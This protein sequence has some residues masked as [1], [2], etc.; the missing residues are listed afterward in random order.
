M[1]INTAFFPALMWNS[2]FS[3]LSGDPF[4]NSAGFVFPAPEGSSLSSEPHLLTAQAF[5]PPTERTE[6]A[7]F[8]FHG[9]N[10]AI[11]AEVA[12][13]ID[14]APAYRRLF[15]EVFPSVR[16]GAPIRF[17]MFARA[18]SEFEFSLTFANAP[19]DRFARGD[20]DAL[21]PAEERGG[22]L[23]FGKAGCAACHSVA[24]SSNEMFTDFRTHA[25]GVPQLVPRLTNNQFDGSAANEDLGREEVTGATQDAFAFRTPSLRNVAVEAAFMHD[26]A[27][28]S[29]R[30]A[31]RHHLDVRDSLLSYDPA[32]QG[33]P[34]DLAGPI[35]PVEPLLEV[36]DPLVARRVELTRSEFDDLVAFVAQGLLDPRAEPAR[37]QALVPRRLPSGRPP[38]TFEFGAARIGVTAGRPTSKR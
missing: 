29:L 12:R 4:D 25:I 21:T 36:L 38:L 9:D 10:D 35:G 5:I 8:D 26:G 37:L 11:R 7:G 24:G 33:L 15:G 23:F 1:A 31:I 28:T 18:I 6:V 27:F 3:S 19:V 32:A 17:A 13:R 2:R 16:S 34:L 30:R 20:G 22:L 14:A